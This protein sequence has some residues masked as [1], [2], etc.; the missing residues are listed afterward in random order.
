ISV[1]DLNGRKITSINEEFRT[2]GNHSV[3][4]NAIDIP[5][6]IYLV[7][8]KSNNLLSLKKMTVIK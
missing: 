4:F 7:K 6:G 5:S 2:A 8:L 3:T 1:Y